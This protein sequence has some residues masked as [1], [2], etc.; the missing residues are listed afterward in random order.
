MWTETE[1]VFKSRRE[2]PGRLPDGGFSFLHP[3]VLKRPGNS[4]AVLVPRFE[5]GQTDKS[6]SCSVLALSWCLR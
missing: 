6:P 3:N 1:R 4:A 2:V 5:D